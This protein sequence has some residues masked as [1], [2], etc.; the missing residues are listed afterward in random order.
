VYWDESDYNRIGLEGYEALRTAGYYRAQFRMR[1]KSGEAVWVDFGAVPLSASEVFV[2][3]VDIT[4]MKQAHES[5]THAVCHDALTLLPNRILLHDRL[6]QAQAAARREASSVAV[7][8]LDLDGFKAINDGHGHDA[9]DHVL[10]VVASRVLS[11]IRPLDTA[12]RLGGDEFVVL[13]A[14]I[15]ADDWRAI[16]ARVI[17]MIAE[18][19]TLR[20]GVA[21]AVGA[22]AGVTLFASG[23]GA[24]AEELIERADRMLLHGKRVGKG[25]IFS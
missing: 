10:K 21:V 24:S 13:L 8:Y 15:H 16:L 7:C 23:D 22:T 19:I 1:R 17:S 2:M 12:A 3:L 20:S 25:R 5:L 14:Q 9:G 4:A 6:R 18:P 11:A